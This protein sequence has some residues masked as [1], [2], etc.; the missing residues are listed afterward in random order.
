MSGEGVNFVQQKFIMSRKV[1]FYIAFFSVLVAGFLLVLVKLIP[2]FAKPQFPPIS[3]VQPFVFTDQDGRPYSDSDVAGKV[4]VAEYFFTTCKGICPRLN[5]NMRQVYDRFKNEPD[6]R[7]LSHTCNPETDSAARL[8]A[9]ADSMGVSTRTWVFLTGRKDS[10]YRQARLSYQSDDP[11]NNVRNPADDFLHTQFFAL[12]DR[13]GDVRRIVDG[14]KPSE[15]RDMFGTIEALL[16][17][18]P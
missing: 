5:N 14:L 2:G 8:K 1:I 3:H 10:L 7:I 17:E 18:K 12:V 13:K 4:Y 16:K 11:K 6:F 9:Y 15:V